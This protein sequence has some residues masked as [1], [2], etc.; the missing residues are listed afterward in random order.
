MNGPENYRA[1]EG[2]LHLVE[3]EPEGSRLTPE[4]LAA[5][6]VHATLALAAATIE[7]IA[8]HGP[9]DLGRDWNDLIW[10]SSGGGQ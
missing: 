8:A 7:Q 6:Q 2:L 1:A 10:P 3:Q 9:A 4:Y 5:A